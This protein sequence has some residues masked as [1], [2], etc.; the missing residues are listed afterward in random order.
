MKTNEELVSE[1]QTMFEAYKGV[2]SVIEEHTGKPLNS[3]LF[4]MSDSILD[5]LLII[6]NIK[7]T[8]QLHTQLHKS[9]EIIL[10][11]IEYHLPSYDKD[12]E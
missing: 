11:T 3:L 7:M 5:T 4:E 8:K 6:D 2:A 12:Q 9:L 1:M 10:L